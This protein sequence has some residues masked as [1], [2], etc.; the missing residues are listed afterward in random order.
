MTKLTTMTEERRTMKI[1]CLYPK[2]IEALKKAKLIEETPTFGEIEEEMNNILRIEA[3]RDREKEWKDK[4]N[5]FLCVGYSNQ[6]P[7]PISRLMNNIKMRHPKLTWIRVR[8][9][10][11]KYANL[12]MLLNGVITKKLN[13]GWKCKKNR[14]RG[15]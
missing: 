3:K 12:S 10:Y 11:H 14:F 2:H 15:L 7:I 8:V 13:Q 6:W 1:E 9:S 4:R 5:V